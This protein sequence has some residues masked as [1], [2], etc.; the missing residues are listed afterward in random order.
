MDG[1]SVTASFI[2][3]LQLTNKVIQYLSDVNDAPK[4]CQ[5]CIIEASNLL[6]PLLSLRYRAEQ[7]QV[8]D[9]WFEQLRKLN[10]RDG[11]LDQY[12]QSLDQLCSIAEQRDGAL[13]LK[14][15]LLWKFSKKE[16]MNILARMDRV[17]SLISI[18][19]EMD[20]MQV[21]TRLRLTGELTLPE[22]YLK[23]LKTIPLPFELACLLCK[24]VLL[25]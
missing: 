22:N 4:D 17:K 7:A 16:V 5:Q 20:H 8:G 10:V 2:A 12:K 14:R 15:R 13:E 24:Q 21:L 11:P 1:L 19:L 9:P 23:L 25:I 6:T 3:I 18:A